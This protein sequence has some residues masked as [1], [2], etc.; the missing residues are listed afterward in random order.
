MKLLDDTKFSIVIADVEYNENHFITPRPYEYYIHDIVAFTD[1]KYDPDGHLIP[2][3]SWLR[4][5]NY[6]ELRE[7][8]NFL[9]EHPE[10]HDKWVRW[11]RKQM[12]HEYVSGDYVYDCIK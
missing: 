8:I 11:G 4:V 7:K 6:K 1:N 10:E 3:D 2:L 9:V 5:N 12:E